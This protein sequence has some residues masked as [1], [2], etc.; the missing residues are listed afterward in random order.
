MAN[1]LIKDCIIAYNEIYIAGNVKDVSV[2]TIVELIKTVTLNNEDIQHLTDILL[3]KQSDGSTEWR[4]KNDPLA[5]VKKQLQEKEVA[6]EKAMK[7]LSAAVQKTRE[8]RNELEVEKSRQMNSREKSQQMQIEI[9]ALH[10]KLQQSYDNHRSEISG[11]QKQLQQMQVKSNDERS[12]ALRLQEDNSRLQ[13]LVKSEQHLKHEIEQLRNERQQC[14][15]RMKALQK[16]SEELAMK[17]QQLESRIKNMSDTRQKDESSYQMH[18][19]DVNQELQ[20]CETQRKA[21]VEELT[22]SNNKCNS[23][24][25]DSIQMRNRLKDIE[26]SKNEEVKRL[27]DQLSKLSKEKQV[28]ENALIETKQ[29]NQNDDQNSDST[30]QELVRVSEEL[31]LVKEQMKTLK[32]SLDVQMKLNEEL[33]EKNRLANETIENFDQV[34]RECALN[35]TKLSEELNTQ[36]KNDAQDLRLQNESL[37][38]K[39]NEA[40]DSINLK[41]KELESVKSELRLIDPSLD[42]LSNDWVTNIRSNLNEILENKNLNNLSEDSVKELELLLQTEKERSNELQLKTKQFAEALGQTVSDWQLIIIKIKL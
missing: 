18:I 13:Q 1:A 29:K 23:L 6:L 36:L 24:E 32:D 19:Q 33:S 22:H 20:K 26:D 41:V 12:H 17:N 11:I 21:L 28:V 3:N 39:L 34:K 27:V 2:K 16:S 10:M 5:V 15:M 4:K 31:T 42:T 25:S 7:N 40:L 38:T 9:Q 14:D 8:L 30:R 37:T 35:A